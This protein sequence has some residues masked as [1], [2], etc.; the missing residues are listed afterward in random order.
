M[1]LRTLLALAWRESRFARRRLLLFLSA[2]S[3]GVASL[4]AVQGF[5]GS[6][7]RGVAREAR[8]LLGADLVLSSRQAFGPLTTALVDSLQRAGVPVARRTS[9]ASMGVAPTGKTRLVQVRAVEPGYPFYGTIETAPAGAWAALQ[10]GANVLVDPG[11]MTALGLRVGDSLGLGAIRFRVLG[12]LVR[13]PGDAAIASSFAPRVAIPARFLKAT[14]LVGFGSRVE[15]DAYFRLPQPAQAGA[16]QQ[17]Y[18]PRLRPERV[19]IGTAAT[20][21]Q[22]LS[23]A[24]GRLGAYLSLV[25]VFALLLGGI[26]VASAMGAHMA[27]KS[28]TVAILRCLGATAAQ[29]LTLYLVQAAVMGLAGRAP[30]HRPRARRGMGAAEA[31]GRPAPRDGDAGGGPPRRPDR[32][33]GGRGHGGAVRAPAP[34]RHPGGL[35]ARRAPP[36][37]QP[38]APARARRPAPA[39]VGARGGRGVRAPVRAGAEPRAGGGDARGHRRGA[40][41]PRGRGVAAR[42]GPAARPRERPALPRPA[43]ARQ[44]LPPRQ[45]DARASCSRSASAC[46]CSAR[47]S[48]CSA[49]CS[50]PSP[51]AMPPRAPTCCSSTCRTTRS[52][53]CAPSSPR[54]AC[55]WPSGPPSSPCA[56]RR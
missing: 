5:A 50:R 6:L 53:A 35:A 8:S 55:R 46:F 26:G 47:S 1:T 11:L 44:P 43:G 42:A 20:E 30:R 27:Q 48:P 14:G 16:V 2:I 56:S 18:R 29:V 7:A 54:R 38:G 41:G 28:D 9:F 21:Q 17:Q 45:P 25:G 4:V 51:R 32:P 19:R 37:H 24:F 10:Q 13:V 52:R 15:Y 23:D 39:R 22:N 31:R 36:P 12:A 34:A 3:L 49:R 40:R 33:G